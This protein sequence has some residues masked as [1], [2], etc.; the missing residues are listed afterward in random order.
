M[1]A[2]IVYLTEEADVTVLGITWRPLFTVKQAF[3]GMLEGLAGFVDSAVGFVFFLPVLVLWLAVAVAALWVARK[4]FRFVKTK[5][6]S[7]K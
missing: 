3:R 2:I 5:F 7:A 1:S 4:A 6:F